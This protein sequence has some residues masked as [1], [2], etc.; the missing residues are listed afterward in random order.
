MI[1]K[2]EIYIPCYNTIRMLHI[3]LPS[4]YDHTKQRYPVLYMYDGHNLFCD[5]EATYGKCWGLKDYLDKNKIPIIIVGIECNHDGNKRL[6]E[7]SPYDFYDNQVGRIK[8]TGRDLMEWVVNDLKP[9]IDRSFRTKKG[10]KDTGIGGSSMGG[11]MSLYTILHHNDTFSKAACLSSCLYLAMPSI[12]KELQC[13]LNKNTS[14]Y[15]SWGSNEFK[16]KTQLAKATSYH[17]TILQPLIHQ[18][19]QLYPNIILQGRHDEASWEKELPT[20]FSFLYEKTS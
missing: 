11:L 12:Q 9:C 7:F 17:M 1:I 18:G 3:Y 15:L 4:N 5:E 13:E 8:G 10:R 19:I 16:T 20:I 14:I 2:H 6:E